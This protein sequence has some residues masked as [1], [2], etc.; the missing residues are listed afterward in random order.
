MPAR[1]LCFWEK[2]TNTCRCVNWKRRKPNLRTCSGQPCPKLWL[3][4]SSEMT[5]GRHFLPIVKIGAQNYL[6]IQIALAEEL[7]QKGITWGWPNL[8]ENYLRIL[9]DN[10]THVKLHGSRWHFTWVLHTILPELSGGF[11]MPFPNVLTWV[12]HVMQ[13]FFNALFSTPKLIAKAKQVENFFPFPRIPP[14]KY[15]SA[16]KS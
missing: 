4:T 11:C 5:V 7:T 3:L 8:P 15:Y 1:G 9:G 6:N 2:A 14:P 12:P 13:F 10:R 16:Q